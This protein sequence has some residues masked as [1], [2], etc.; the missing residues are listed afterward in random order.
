MKF[1][2]LSQSDYKKIL[3]FYNI[4][5]H[6]NKRIRKKMA[7]NILAEKLCKC[8][9]KITKQRAKKLPVYKNTRK[10]KNI[11]LTQL[12]KD[13]IGICRNSVI[14]KKGLINFSFTCKKKPQLRSKKGK[15]VKLGKK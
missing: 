8:I 15:T 5:L 6:K 3:N 11:S 13:S 9:K 14:S 1:R 2:Y 7:E 10:K 4:P 12:E